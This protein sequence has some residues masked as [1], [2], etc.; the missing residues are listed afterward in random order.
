MTTLAGI[1]FSFISIFGMLKGISKKSIKKIL[2]IAFSL[3][4][5]L[6]QV[7]FLNRIVEV[8][9]QGFIAVS[10]IL[11]GIILILAFQKNEI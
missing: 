9:G 10:G 2:L 1:F 6:V 5:I 3:F 4:L 11:T 7:L 8:G